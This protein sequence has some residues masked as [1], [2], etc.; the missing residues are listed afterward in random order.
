[1]FIIFY[2][3]TIVIMKSFTEKS[4]TSKIISGKDKSR[5]NNAD[6]FLWNYHT[7]DSVEAISCSR[8]IK[9]GELKHW[10]PYTDINHVTENDITH[11]PCSRESDPFVGFD[12]YEK[13]PDQHKLQVSWRRHAMEISEILHGEQLAMLCASQ[14]ITLLPDMEG[15]LFASRQAADEARHVEFFRAYL[16]SARQEITP[17]SA[18]MRELTVETLQSPQWEI[19]LLI[20][21]I[22]IESLAMAHFSFLVRNCHATTLSQG[23]RRIMDDEA[24]HVK[25]GTD[26]LAAM[27]RSHTS[28]QLEQYGNFVVEKAFE[29]ASS[30]NH[31]VVIARQLHWDTHRLRHHLRQRRIN[32]PEL[33]QQ[34][35]RQ[36]TLNIRMTG[37]MNKRLEQRLMRFCGT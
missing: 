2:S 1:M 7:N 21:Q 6:I 26:Y 17:P 35:F 13:L 25:F 5:C 18:V 15:R 23:L 4:P 22:L 9:L 31:C 16:L 37:L 24:R 19:K 28:D 12:E 3:G 30:D 34:R 33:I 32:K 27:F 11:F 36:L 29:L 10:N 20:C 14:L 8:L